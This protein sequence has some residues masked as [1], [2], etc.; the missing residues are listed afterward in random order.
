MDSK[1]LERDRG[2]CAICGMDCLE[3]EAALAEVKDESYRG[4]VAGKW[5]VWEHSAYQA[6][7]NF[8]GLRNR[9]RCW[10]ADHIK[11]VCR[12]GGECGLS[13]YRTLCVWCHRKETSKLR[14]E[15]AA[16]KRRRR[17]KKR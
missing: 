4:L 5:P 16:E 15:L 17:R 7:R 11:P 14:R 8:L 6:L 12:G 10:D 3:V 9:H 13:N 2:I 1:V